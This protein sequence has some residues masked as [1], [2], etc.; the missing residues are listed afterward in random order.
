MTVSVP[1]AFT[2]VTSATGAQLDANFNILSAI[3]DVQDNTFIWCGVAGGSA[4]AITLTPTPAITAYK[5]GRTF[6]FKTGAAANTTAV[7]VQISGLASPRAIQK[8][9]AALV[10]GDMPASSWLTLL[11]DGTNF[12]LINAPAGS[13]IASATTVINVGAATAPTVGQVLTATSGTVA[14]WQSPSG[15]TPA[16]V[17]NQTYTYCGQ[18]TG[19]N[20]ALILTPSPANTSNSPGESFT[21]LCVNGAANTGAVTVNVSGF[22]PVAVYYKGFACQGGEIGPLPRL[23]RI[24]QN[25]SQYDLEKLGATNYVK[26][27]STTF[28]I[29]S[30]TGAGFSFTTTCRADN[31]IMTGATGGGAGGGGGAPAFIAFGGGDSGSCVYTANLSQYA[32]GSFS[33]TAPGGTNFA[34]LQTSAGNRQDIQLNVINATSTSFYNTKVGTPTGTV[35]LTLQYWS[36]N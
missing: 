6:Y 1:N 26:N 7:T 3:S 16:Q 28:D 5:A 8:Q 32:A 27:A 4:N 23:Y 13:N 29:S 19:T 25:A 2:A 24:T 36:N 31:W 15:V 35:T 10:A 30:A 12:Q 14:T 11:D 22:G 20:S 21:F 9:G 34:F 18:A 17:Q 33:T